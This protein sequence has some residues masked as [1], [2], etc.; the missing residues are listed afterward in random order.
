M[1]EIEGGGDEW[2]NGDG[3]IVATFDAG[4]GVDVGYADAVGDAY[5]SGAE[6]HAPDVAEESEEEIAEKEADGGDV[7]HLLAEVTHEV[8][9]EKADEEGDDI[10]A[11][12]DEGGGDGGEVGGLSGEGEV[13]GVDEEEKHDE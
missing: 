7:F 5:E 10:E 8:A 4:D 2:H 13:G 9:E 12:H 6:N 11:Y 1:A 3:S